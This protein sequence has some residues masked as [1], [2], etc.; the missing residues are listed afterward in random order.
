MR[1]F[2]NGK[3]YHGSSKVGQGKLRGATDNS[4]YFYFLCPDCP[5]EQILRVLDYGIRAEERTNPYNEKFKNK[6]NGGFVLA[7]KVHCEACHLTDFVK[8]S[9]IEWQGGSLK[10]ALER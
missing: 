7:F 4:D 6:A 9:N 2:N 8:I 10:T 1:K 5:D 3:P